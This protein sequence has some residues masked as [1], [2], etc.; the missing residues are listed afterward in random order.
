MTIVEDIRAICTTV[1]PDYSFEYEEFKML[2]LKADEKTPEA[3][4]IYLEEFKRGGYKKERY[5]WNKTTTLN[6]YFCG[7][8]D[9]Q[10][11]AQTRETLRNSIETLAVIPF[12]QEYNST[13]AVSPLTDWKFLTPQPQFDANEVSIILQFEY[14]ETICI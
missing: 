5:F 10:A 6:L 14:R 2:N 9:F 12:I 4:V 8:V 13:H 3:K 1:A 7:F 11:D